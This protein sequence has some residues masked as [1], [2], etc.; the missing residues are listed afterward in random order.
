MR[1]AFLALALVPLAALSVGVAVAGDDSPKPP[2]GTKPADKP[3]EKPAGKPAEKPASPSASEPEYKGP[4]I[5][6]M[7]SLADAIEE[8]A[9]RNVLL[10]I[11]SH[12]ST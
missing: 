10:Y 12:G 8:G 6:W 11:H 1:C 4:E 2:V 7:L 3:A 5:H 9:Q